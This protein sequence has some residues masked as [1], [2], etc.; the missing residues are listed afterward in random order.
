MGPGSEARHAAKAAHGARVRGTMGLRV[1][2][3]FLNRIKLIWVVQS[4]EKK[5]TACDLTQISR[6]SA[7]VS[8]TEGR[9]AIV[10]DAG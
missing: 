9:I 10:T 5:F 7:T 6:M 1:K 3:N 8:P 2:T 4:F